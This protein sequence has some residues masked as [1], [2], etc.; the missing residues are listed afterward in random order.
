MRKKKK[1]IAM[2]MTACV[3]VG[4][5]YP[6]GM[7]GIVNA[8]KLTYTK[9]KVYD[10]TEKY[11][12]KQPE[13]YN[14]NGYKMVPFTICNT[15]LSGIGVGDGY[16]LAT[17][18]MLEVGDKVVI[19]FENPID[20]KKFEMVTISMKQ[21]PGNSYNAYNA[22]DNILSTA[23][24][25]F[26]IGSYGVERI[27]FE[28][29][30]FADSK[31]MVNAI[32]LQNTGA[33]E[34]GQLFIDEFFVSASPYEKGVTYDVTNEYVK[35][36]NTNSYKG[37]TVIPFG[38][39][40]TFWT[41][42]AK[43]DSDAGY[44]LIASKP[45]GAAVSEGEVLILEFVNEIKKKDFKYLNI[46][47][48][49]A[50]E[51]G[52]TIELY[53]VNDIKNGKLGEVKQTADVDYWGFNTISLK[54]AD[55]ADANGCVGAIA[56]KLTSAEALTFSVG[57][58]SLTDEPEKVA[59]DEKSESDG[60]VTYDAVDTQNQYDATG[61]NLVIQKSTKYN[62][63]TILPFSGCNTVLAELGMG[64]GYALCVEEN[65]EV[66]DLMVLE[67]VN[68]VDS[69][70]VDLITISLKQTPGN[71]YE[72]YKAS[73]TTFSK[74][75]KTLEVGSYEIEKAAFRTSLFADSDGMVRSI[76]LKNTKADTPGQLF[77]DGYDLGNDP[78]ALDVEYD[79]TEDFIKVQSSD[80][81]KGMKVVPFTERSVFWSKE[82][83]LEDGYSV[84]ANKP[85]GGLL[86][87]GDVMILE[88]VTDISAKDFEV[89]NLSLVTSIETG[90]IFEV[91][92]VNEIQNGKLGQVRARVTADFWSFKTNNIAL[93]SLA[94]ENG[95]VGAI[96]L[97]LISEEAQ[98]FSVGSF[99]LSALSSLVE[100]NAPEILDNKITVFETD[101]AYEFSVEFNKAGSAM[102][103]EK[104][105]ED[106][107]TFNG[108]KL[109]D[110][111]KEGTHITAEWQ[112]MGR[113]Y[114]SVTVDKAYDGPGA[115]I[116]T[117]KMLVGN[118]IEL[119]KGMKLP[120]GD[121]LS[122]GYAL[123]VYSVDN[124]TEAR[125]E[126]EDYGAIEIDSIS[127][128]ID[129]NDNL[130]INVGF[131]N[132]I[133][134][135]TM[136]FVCNPDSFNR[137]SV[138]ALN[139]DVI[140][141]EENLASAFIYGGYKS[142]VLDNLKLN[143]SSIGE[144]LAIDQL[145]GSLAYA[146]AIMVHYGQGG[147]KVATIHISSSSKIYEE[148]KASY[149]DNSLTLTVEEGLKF[150]TGK[151]VKEAVTYEYSDDVW[152]KLPE[153]EFVVYYDGQKVEDGENISVANAPSAN[154][155]EVVGSGEYTIQEKAVGTTAEY[156]ILEGE[157]ELLHFTVEGKTI[158]PIEE[159]QE[160]DTAGYGIVA[161]IIVIIL[162]A[163]VVV[164]LAVRRKKNAKKENL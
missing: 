62:D 106:M 34:Q 28:T 18:G 93:E 159:P 22:S 87:K 76:V 134:G 152:S 147:T 14:F 66:G 83:E 151:E 138:A 102:K 2:L 60:L 132:Q 23:R 164:I 35:Q 128:G 94:D 56:L 97:K 86:T 8:A 61:E 148:L 10:A 37:L 39:V 90:A 21:V 150:A 119:E 100:E 95:Y 126:A 111:N 71:S 43:L 25:S 121:S 142:S 135:A 79:A 156:V 40:G 136:Y 107:I 88:F 104:I 11:F 122:T 139:G 50:T 12:T 7:K 118:C 69:N 73:D 32:I 36:Q 84:V 129:E 133:T 110:I 41:E 51:S 144:W 114:L 109:S 81:Y 113:Y 163:A 4:S 65:V 123:H 45:E 47:F 26:S 59:G 58:F 3:L 158:V 125:N 72:V 92:N 63:M 155:I 146:S 24:K 49:T 6:G 105:S 38:E 130:V 42:Q 19:E 17:A 77:I 103:E 54:T 162:L 16:S 80:E 91:Y 141:Y 5:V 153:S 101:T 30:L 99:S 55:F 120:D 154:N 27:S 68:P 78:Y 96:A 89:L 67:F 157:T 116:N 53:N 29:A 140:F 115:V 145:E 20:S 82:A 46:S 160:N 64:E 108:V 112:L 137:T 52:A 98:T 70:S 161:G 9:D 117:D 85:E 15:Y 143:G 124:I 57:G 1:I 74:A 48:T 149:M 31:G 44:G 75:V 13:E 131:S 33:E 127:S